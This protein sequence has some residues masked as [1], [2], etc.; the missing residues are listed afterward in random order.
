M[1]GESIYLLIGFIAL[2][3]YIYNATK[4]EDI[5]LDDMFVLFVV[6][7]AWPFALSL[8]IFM[9]IEDNKDKVIFK[10]KKKEEK[11]S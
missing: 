9:L 4:T 6:F 2:C 10:A 5:K 11:K 3:C 8:L 1:I 7:F